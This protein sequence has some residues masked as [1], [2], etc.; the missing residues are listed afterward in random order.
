M[1]EEI[2]KSSHE[3]YIQKRK[4]KRASIQGIRLKLRRSIN[5]N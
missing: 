3:K 5:T 2:K 4:E 1:L